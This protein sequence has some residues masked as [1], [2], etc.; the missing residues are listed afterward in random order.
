MRGELVPLEA[1]LA[2]LAGTE[3]EPAAVLLDR[4]HADRPARRRK[5]RRRLRGLT[6]EGVLAAIRRTAWGS[7][8]RTVEELVQAVAL[9]LKK[10]PEPGPELQ[11]TLRGHVEIAIERR[12]LARQGDR[13]V[14]ATPKIG[15]YDDEFLLGAV[16]QA[17]RDGVSYDRKQLSRAVASWLGYDQLTAAMSERLDEIRQEA[18]RRGLLAVEGERYRFIG[19]KDS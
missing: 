9:R 8:E 3:H 10:T 17:M 5:S 2:R 12:I 15:R 13:L 18:I 7:L 16:G 1:E 19:S 11:A 4:I 6:T 14:S